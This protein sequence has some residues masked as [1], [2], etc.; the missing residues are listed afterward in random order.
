[1]SGASLTALGSGYLAA[2]RGF[3]R[4]F[5]VGSL[6]TASREREGRARKRH[7]F[8]FPQEKKRKFQ[9]KGQADDDDDVAELRCGACLL[10]GGPSKGGERADDKLRMGG[11]RKA[12]I[13]GDSHR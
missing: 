4:L 7:E 9:R 2:P 10:H 8:A 3:W 6:K 5:L 11:E 1:M 13:R 12:A